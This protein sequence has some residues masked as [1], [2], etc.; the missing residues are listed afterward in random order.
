MRTAMRQMASEFR[1]LERGKLAKRLRDARKHKTSL[2]GHAVI[3]TP[4]GFRPGD[5]LGRRTLTL[6]LSHLL[7]LWGETSQP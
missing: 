3:G 5:R 4:F 7:S 2:G 1:Q 6:S